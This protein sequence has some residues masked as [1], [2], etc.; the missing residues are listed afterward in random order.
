MLYLTSFRMGVPPEMLQ[1]RL[2]L[3]LV[4]Q[5]VFAR[6]ERAPMSIADMR[7][8]GGKLYCNI[9]QQVI[10]LMRVLPKNYRFRSFW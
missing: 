1:E 6:W 9:P 5:A 4:H 2:V 10:D 7:E 8:T 3:V